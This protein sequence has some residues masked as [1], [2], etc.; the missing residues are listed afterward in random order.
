VQDEVKISNLSDIPLA[1]TGIDVSG[2]SAA[3][4]YRSGV[5][6]LYNI[7]GTGSGAG[8]AYTLANGPTTVAYGVEYDDGSGFSPLT[9]GAALPAAGGESVND[10][11]AT[12]GADNGTVQ[13]TVLAVDAAVLPALVYTGTLTLLVAPI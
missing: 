13:V 11:C 4:V 2:T 8:G 3:C 12:A 5:T 10:D 9:S 6:G 7:T 1:F